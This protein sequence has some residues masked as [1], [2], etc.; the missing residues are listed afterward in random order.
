MSG[1]HRQGL[2]VLTIR[3]VQRLALMARIFL[4]SCLRFDRHK[5]Q[6]YRGHLPS[7]SGDSRVPVLNRQST[8]ACREVKLSLAT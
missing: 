8:C 1:S 3:E 7:F 2:V 4:S 5:T 6:R